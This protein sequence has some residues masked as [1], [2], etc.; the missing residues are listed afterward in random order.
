A[1]RLRAELLA[2]RSAP[3]TPAVTGLLRPR[4]SIPDGLD[5][6]LSWRELDA[7][8]LHERTHARR[9]DNLIKLLH[10]LALCLLRFHPLVW[11]A[12]ARL[13]LYRELSCDDSVIRN[14]RGPEL[15]S[16]LAKLARSDEAFLL[17][18]GAASFIRYRLARLAGEPAPSSRAATALL[19]GLFAVA[20]AWGI[21][22][23]ISHTACCFLGR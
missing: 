17:Q 20:L 16:A 11:L 7:V 4:V 9:R 14:A 23:T 2:A 10:E 6:L 22:A 8:L 21:L 18:A 13:A 5:R 15:V 12:G 1:L 3:P 19:A